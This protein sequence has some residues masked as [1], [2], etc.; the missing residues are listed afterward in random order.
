MKY[1]LLLTIVSLTLFLIERSINLDLVVWLYNK[2]NT[3][4]DRGLPCVV[5]ITIGLI[6]DFL[7][8]LLKRKEREKIAVYYETMS[9][10][11]H[12]LRNL[13]NHLQIINA[14]DSL[15]KEFGKETIGLLNESSQEVEDIISR[16]S[17]LKTINPEIIKEIAYSNVSKTK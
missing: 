14:S 16:L 7:R 11:N 17:H 2:H 6:L 13:Q 1:T 4:F 15:E 12:L 9:G 5:F 10:V 3:L 8:F